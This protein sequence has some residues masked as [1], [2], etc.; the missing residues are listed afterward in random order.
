VSDDLLRQVDELRHRLQQLEDERAILRVLH[1]YGPALDEGDDEAWA[2]C[3]TADGV[4][5]TAGAGV[6]Q[7]RHL[8]GRAELVAFARRHTRAPDHLHKHCVFDSLIELDGDAARVV[9]YFVRFDA[10]ADGPVV[11]AFGRYHDRLERGHD[12]S[13]RIA[14]RRAEVQTTGPR[15]A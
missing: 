8:Q 12:G 3:F 10:L 6:R 9:S 5:E 15:R 11:F 13:W 7:A 1:S 4:W 2:R 14:H